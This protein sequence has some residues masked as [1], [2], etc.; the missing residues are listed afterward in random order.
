MRILI[1]ANPKSGNGAAHK[2]LPRLKDFFERN[3]AELDV[4]ITKKQGDAIDIAKKAAKSGKY[5]VIVASGGDGTVNEVVNGIMLSGRSKKQ[6]FGIIPLG[7]ENVLAQETHIPFDSFKAAQLIINRKTM[8]M[9]IGLAGKR[10]F[11]LMAGIGF[12]AH[13][14]T[15]VQPLL[16][17]LIGSAAYPIA[18]WNELFKYR[19]SDITVM[20]DDGKKV[21][22][23]FVVI[24]NTKLYGAKLKITPHADIHD[25]LLDVCVFKGKDLLSFMRY[26]LGTITKQHLRFSDIEYHH[27]KN[28]SISSKPKVLCH[29]DCELI[30]YT[31]LKVKIV[32]KAINLISKAEN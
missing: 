10:Y 21:K 2:V 7:T 12:D 17:K 26:A 9:D 6:M 8:K 4:Y 25:G 24:G 28:I 1:I 23:S 32:P 31:P 11:V 30:G 27:A 19:H 18:A 3:Y 20:M 14:S 16:K 13:V 5:D 29:V 15:K 22:G